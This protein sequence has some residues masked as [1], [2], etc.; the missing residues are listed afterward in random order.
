MTVDHDRWSDA[1]GSYLLGALPEDEREPYEAHLAACAECRE[2]I[3]ELA[4][5]V[6]ALPAS[7]QPMAPPPALKSRIMADVQREAALLA[8]AG[9]EA[10][11]VSEPRRRRRRWSLPQLR[12]A[13][14]ATAAVLLLA[15]IG[16][17]VAATQLDEEG[18]TV[19]ATVDAP[20]AGA[21]LE[22]SGETATL[23]ARNLP[24]PPSG[25]VYQVWL[26]RPGEAAEP[27]SVL[28]TPDSEGTAMASVPGP[29]EGVEKVM[30]TSEPAGGS[31][32]P[33]EQPIV[34]AE[35]S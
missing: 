14:V 30:V 27:T 11:R 17:G 22:L 7:V 12:L 21:E 24:A 8:A 28:F 23:V 6:H 15:G 19:V 13:P 35:L 18:R 29:L 32:T 9:P 25:R 2:E 26:K 4:P 1:A 16:I 31:M 34:V 20:D 33:T 10:D 5:A 3:D